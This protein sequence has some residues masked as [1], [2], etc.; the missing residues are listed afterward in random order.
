MKRTVT[1]VV[2]MILSLSINAQDKYTQG[3]EKAF[4]L[5]NDGKFIEASHMFER[6]A[7]ATPDNW[8]PYYYA[9]Q[10]L[11]VDAFSKLKDSE[12]LQATLE[13]AQGFLDVAK[14]ISPKN[15]EIMVQQAMIHTAYIASDGATYGASLSP[16]VQTLY[17]TA[18]QMEPDN[19]R[20]VYLQAEWNMGAAQFFGKDPSV[21]CNDL[22]R[23]MEL[24]A[25][26]KPKG[27]FYPD[28][29]KE[30]A[31]TLLNNCASK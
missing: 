16:K 2:L 21:Y 13:K 3:M 24:F 5:Y 17:A 28:W 18:Q 10:T 26:F 6:I 29:G 31:E 14:G 11:N 1:L 8:L 15:V 19:P 23:A 30:R 4:G 9:A 12:K 25:T 7:M 20:V 27:P 22:K